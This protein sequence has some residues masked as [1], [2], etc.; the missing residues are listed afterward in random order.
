MRHFKILGTAIGVVLFL[1]TFRLDVQAAVQY[2][3]TPVEKLSEDEDEEDYITLKKDGSSYEIKSGDTLW[4]ISKSFLGSGA[5]YREIFEDNTGVLSDANFLMPGDVIHISERLYIPKDRYDRGGLVYEGA[6]HIAMPDIVEN[7]L[8]LTTDISSLYSNSPGIT[9]HSL[10]VTNHMGENAL[11]KDWEHFVSEVERCSETCGGRVSGL[12]FEKYEVEN[13]CD[14]C[15]YYFDFDTGEGIVEFAAFFRFGTQNM[16]EVIGVRQ[17][18]ANTRL[19]DVTRYIAASFEDFGG[20]NGMGFVK[21][22]DNV[23]AFDWDYPEL[24]NLFTAAMTEFIDYAE[25]PEENMPGDYELEWDEPMF[26]DAVRSALE[27]LW[28]LNEEEKKEFRS[29]PLMASDVAVIKRIECRLYEDGYPYADEDSK[30]ATVPVLSFTLNG[31]W[32]KLYPE[33]EGM[34]SWQDLKHFRNVE[35]ID[36][37]VCTLSDYSFLA[38]MPH[39]KSL[40]IWAGEE[41]DNVDFLSGLTELRTLSLRQYYY[42]KGREEESAFFHITDISILGN[43]PELAYVFLQMPNVKDYSFLKNCP[44]IC[45][46]ELS[47]ELREEEPVI[48]DVDL[49]KNARFLEFYDDGIRFL[50]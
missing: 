39:L 11:T 35:T 2:D 9:I 13:G 5:R 37:R 20:K 22:T 1:M 38:E 43:C 49:L 18:E 44:N 50:P 41:V 23:G 29:R 47:G 31:Y 7:N 33:E 12:T 14:L 36:M 17:K 28:Q 8:F 19:V 32:Q 6:T 46:M 30:D 10:P 21:T 34:S 25:R 16:A 24:H 48:P 42:Y 4:G 45:T 15:G 40:T 27:E 3:Y 26:E